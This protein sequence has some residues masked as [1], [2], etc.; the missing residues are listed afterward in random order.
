MKIS[1]KTPP[2][3]GIGILLLVAALASADT[4]Y[5]KNGMYIIVTMAVDKGGEVEYWV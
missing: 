3:H 2:L 5:L 4:I 1:V